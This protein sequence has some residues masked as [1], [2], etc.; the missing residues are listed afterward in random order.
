MKEHEEDCLVINCKYSV[1]LEK[2]STS[3]KNYFKQLSVPFN[4]YA[5]FECILKKVEGDI[6]ECDSNSSYTRKYQD[7]IPCSFTYKIV[8]I[9]NKL[10]KKVFLYKGK[11]AV[12]KF[13][14]SILSEYSYCRKVTKNYFNKNL[15][16][17]RI[18]FIRRRKKIS[19]E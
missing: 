15:F 16:I 2:G 11:D 6:I 10:S 5:D 1:K 18:Y 3:F 13:I 4:I 17:R 12:S 19:S 7:H 9:D 14:K 8:C